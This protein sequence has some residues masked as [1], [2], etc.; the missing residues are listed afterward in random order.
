MLGS[1]PGAEDTGLDRAVELE[2]MDGWTVCLGQHSIHM[3]PTELFSIF[4]LLLT[5][6]FLHF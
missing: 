4:S 5:C 1:P 3:S 2:K 6:R